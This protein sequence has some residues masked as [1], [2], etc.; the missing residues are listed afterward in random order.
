[1]ISAA[2][3]G[4]QTGDLARLGDLLRLERRELGLEPL[5]DELVQP[6][7]PIDVLEPV[8]A[9]LSDGDASHLVLDQLAGR[10]REQHL[11]AVADRPDAGR[12]MHS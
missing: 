5:D 4:S 8:G 2:R 6:L 9:E 10:A 7:G 3:G 11:A 1:M 12:A